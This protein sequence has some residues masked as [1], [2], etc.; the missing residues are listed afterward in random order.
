MLLRRSMRQ[1]VEY[2]KA[3]VRKCDN[4]ARYIKS[5]DE[6][7]MAKRREAERLT[8]EAKLDEERRDRVKAMVLQ[9]MRD[10][11]KKKIEGATYTLSRVGNGGVQAVDIPQ[12]ELVPDSLKRIT[13]TLPFEIW[14]Y[15]LDGDYNVSAKPEIVAAGSSANRQGRAEPEPDLTAIRKELEKRVPCSKCDGGGKDLFTE[16]ETNCE[17]CGGTGEVANGVPG[18]VLKPPLAESLRIK[19]EIPRETGP[20]PHGK[21]STRCARWVARCNPWRRSGKAVLICWWGVRAATGS[22]KLRTANR[23]ISAPFC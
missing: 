14:Q 11:D 9:I 23:R 21:W 4:I 18:C 17:Y 16:A 10:V 1:I 6:H 7:A 8:H 5:C 2:V 3:E 22:W 13:L 15:I 20:E 12:P 19:M